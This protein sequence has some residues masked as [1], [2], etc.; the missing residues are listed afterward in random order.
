[1]TD[2]LEMLVETCR[3]QSDI[4]L[5]SQ[6]L[7]LTPDEASRTSRPLGKD[8]IE[9]DA[10]NGDDDPCWFLANIVGQYLAEASYQLTALAHLIES[11]AVHATLEPLIR[12]TLERCGRV[13][14][15]L[16]D[17]V[18]STTRA[19]RTHLE[20]FVCSNHYVKAL[21]ALK[22]HPDERSRLREWKKDHEA[23]VRDRFQLVPDESSN[24]TCKW[25]LNDEKYPGYSSVVKYALD[26][27]PQA[28]AI[29]ASLSGFSHPNTLFGL[30]RVH[31][32]EGHAVRD[33]I[34]LK[35][36]KGLGPVL[37]RRSR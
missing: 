24:A 29:Y 23:R 25:I 16:D 27:H 8:S 30:E 12:A 11:R 1:M 10:A 22:A 6:A 36:N 34:T 14:W 35:R 32:R 15:L 9:W 28:S 37:P 17:E 4:Y 7:T 20:L 21:K 5:R 2:I 18:D 31:R 33:R 26:S 13:C 19:A 3:T